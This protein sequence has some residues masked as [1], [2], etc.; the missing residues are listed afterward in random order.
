MCVERSRYEGPGGPVWHDIRMVDSWDDRVAAFWATADDVRPETMLNEM[1]A[2]VSERGA[3]DAEALY[4]WASVHDFLGREADAIPFYRAALDEGLTGNR[5]LQ[6][7]VQL[8]SSLRNVGESGAAIELLE[9]QPGEPVTGAA[10]QAFLALA[11]HDSGRPSEALRVA[12][13]ALARTLPLYG[14]AITSYADELTDLPDK[15]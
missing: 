15:R 9:A 1:N 3:G 4:E 12:L 10:A 8:A 13:K 6:A 11:L 7:V 2:L 14:R 5:R